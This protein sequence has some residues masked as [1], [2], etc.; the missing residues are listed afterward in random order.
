MNLA[1]YEG[2]EKLLSDTA[3]S[4][5]DSK[6]KSYTAGNEDVLWNFKRDG[7]ETGIGPMQ[8]WLQHLLKQVAAVVSYVKHPDVK[9][10]ETLLSRLADI[11]NYTTLGLGLAVDEGREVIATEPA[12][13]KPAI[14]KDGDY[15]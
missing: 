14:H 6:R 12:S 8:N 4:I 7:N 3:K 1:Q 2:L 9:P 13:N 5:R 10:S 15:E 11:R